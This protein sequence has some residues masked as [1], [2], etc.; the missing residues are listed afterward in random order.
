M[1]KLLYLFLLFPLLSHSQIIVTSANLPNIGDTVITA[2]DFGNYSPG[3]S[4]ASQNW[5]FSNAAGMPDMLLGFIDPLVT[6]YQS[7]FPSSNICAKVDSW[8]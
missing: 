4:G 8:T 3:P 7:S 6:P 5:N 1:K 2:E